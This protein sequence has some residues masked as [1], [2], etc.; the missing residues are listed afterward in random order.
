MF[1]SW[2]RYIR[3]WNNNRNFGFVIIF[4]SIKQII[5]I[6]KKVLE[7]FILS[8][9]C[10]S[11]NT[12]RSIYKTYLKSIIFINTVQII[13]RFYY[14]M[15]KCRLIK[16]IKAILVANRTIWTFF[17]IEIK[18]MLNKLQISQRWFNFN[19][20]GNYYLHYLACILVYSITIWIRSRCWVF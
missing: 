16:K 7:Y 4:N 10:I 5:R 3:D 13:W 14:P 18:F 9:L 19:I 12:N 8:I 15:S 6:Y 11:L 20:W 17:C 1:K 2:I